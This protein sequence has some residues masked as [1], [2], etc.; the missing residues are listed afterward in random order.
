LPVDFLWL[1]V[2]AV[3]GLLIGSFLNV[4]IYRI[5]RD[6]SVV[7]PRSF[8]PE[9]GAQIRWFQN[10]PVL[11]YV[12]LRGKCAS[13]W[14]PIGW[15]YP[16]VEL[17]TGALFART[18]AVYGVSL[19]ALKWLV[20]E[21]ILIVLFATDLEERFLPDELTIG[22]SVVGLILAVFVGVP[23]FAG[24][25]LPNAGMIVRSLLN[26]AVGACLLSVPIGLIGFAYQKIRHRDGLGQGDVKLLIL[27][28]I[29]LG[30]Q[31]GV[32]AALIA[33]VGGSV[34]GVLY[35]VV[36]RKNIATY[37]LPFGSFLCVGAGIAPLI[38]DISRQM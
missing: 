34:L 33:A 2:A 22:G 1:V 3:A 7:A 13:C 21:A 5:P 25:L 31:Q 20:F 19:A 11:S 18:V 14:K 8:C 26:A 12:F 27:M 38:S 32:W 29:F 16:A 24:L 28:G 30:V 37:E 10:V 23:G 17:A 4:C 15:R 35:I 9:C 36:R 6:I